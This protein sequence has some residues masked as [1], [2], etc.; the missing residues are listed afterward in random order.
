VNEEC[1]DFHRGYDYASYFTVCERKKFL[2]DESVE[3]KMILK[4]IFKRYNGAGVH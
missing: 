3:G 1:T 4:R 2:G